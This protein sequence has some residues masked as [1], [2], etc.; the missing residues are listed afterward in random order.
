MDD[1]IDKPN[2][3]HKLT[4]E[5]SVELESNNTRE[6]FDFFEIP[7]IIND[8]VDFLQPC[9]SPYESVIYWFIFRHSIVKTG[10]TLV[11][12][13]VTR[14][15]KGIGSKFKTNDKPLTASDKTI[16]E[17]LRALEKKGVI[18]KTGDTTREGTLYR[19][20]LPEEIEMCRQ[21]MH[22]LQAVQ[23]PTI[24]PK[25][26]QDYYNVKENRLKIFERDKYLCYK[27]NK[28]LT[29]FNATLD[30]IQPISKHGDNSYDNLVTS[31]FH[32]N[33]SRRASPISDFLDK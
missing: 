10:G 20:L 1:Q 30:H 25:K 22:E 6:V 21:R 9:L 5:Y 16:S 26:E 7:Q 4:E 11:R 24:D 13:S 32:C 15:S 2:L 18:K 23:L 8:I 33:T 14:L 19:I 12:L 3:L 29:R 31:C 27:C 17:N 28:L